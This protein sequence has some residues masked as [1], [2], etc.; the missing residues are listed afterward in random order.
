MKMPLLPTAR[1]IEGQ[2]PKCG[3]LALA[4]IENELH[5]TAPL[6]WHNQ[7]LMNGKI[8]DRDRARFEMRRRGGQN[9]FKRGRS[10]CDDGFE[11]ATILEPHR[12]ID[13]QFGFVER[14]RRANP[15]A[16]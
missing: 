9:H 15:T 7:S 16:Q 4:W 10:G 2:Y 6:G 1:F 5:R 11:N 12:P 3:C 8:F 13:A 14:N